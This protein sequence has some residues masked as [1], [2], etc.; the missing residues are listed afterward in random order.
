MMGNIFFTMAA[1]KGG[2]PSPWVS[3]STSGSLYQVTA[4]AMSPGRRTGRSRRFPVAVVRVGGEAPGM[5]ISRGD[6]ETVRAGMVVDGQRTGA[7]CA[8]DQPIRLGKR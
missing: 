3:R 1:S 5:H 7:G 6:A 4:G 2:G 8:C